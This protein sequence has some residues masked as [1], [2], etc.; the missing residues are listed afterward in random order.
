MKLLITEKQLKQIIS[1]SLLNEILS[2]KMHVINNKLLE[3]SE[4]IYI[5]A[6]GL[7]E[8]LETTNQWGIDGWGG[9]QGVSGQKKSFT[10][11]IQTIKH[12]YPYKNPLPLKIRELYTSCPQ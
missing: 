2:E 4:Y 11:N 5:I 12:F 1:E 8:E 10:L 9:L 6:K 7:S 3:L